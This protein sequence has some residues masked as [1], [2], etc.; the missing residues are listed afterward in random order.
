M[1]VSFGHVKSFFARIRGGVD[2]TTSVPSMFRHGHQHETTKLR[3]FSLQESFV[4]FNV[5]SGSR[6]DWR[7]LGADI[8]GVEGAGHGGIIGAFD[9]RPSVRK[10][11]QLE[12]IH[13]AAKQVFI[14]LHDAELRQA[15]LQRVQ[16]ER[17]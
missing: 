16:V 10:D 14:A 12:I 15:I 3:L 13:R 6:P 17:P 8:L 7:G 5:Q 11:R 4:V 1:H 2:L 9:D